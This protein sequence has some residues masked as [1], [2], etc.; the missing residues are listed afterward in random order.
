M[1]QLPDVLALVSAVQ[2]CV[3]HPVGCVPD[4]RAWGAA[5]EGR[6]AA[7]PEECVSAVCLWGPA[8][9]VWIAN[10]GRPSLTASGAAAH[11]CED[12]CHGAVASLEDADTSRA[13][14]HHGCVASLAVEHL[15]QTER[16]TW[17]GLL[18]QGSPQVY[19]AQ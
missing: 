9:E 7:C 19:D 3:V 6:V 2:A 12:G 15:L 10:P 5:L 13:Q 11:D 8:A 4:V 1:G 18:R 16:A 17:V 14:P